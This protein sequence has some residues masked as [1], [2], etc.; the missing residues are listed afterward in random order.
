M[1]DV[2]KKGKD[3]FRFLFFAWA[4]GQ[5]MEL[6]FKIE[7][8]VVSGSRERGVLRALISALSVKSYNAC[9]TT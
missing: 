7:A 9:A 4:A 1:P 8:V 3:D 5:R 2:I 6:P